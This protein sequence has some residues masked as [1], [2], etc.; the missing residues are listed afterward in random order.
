M[1]KSLLTQ[2]QRPLSVWLELQAYARILL[3]ANVGVPSVFY[4]DLF[5]MYGPKGDQPA[6]VFQ[7]PRYQKILVKMMLVRRFYAYGE[8]GEYFEQPH[9]IGF[10]RHGDAM[11]SNGAGIA[12]LLTSSFLDATKWMCVGLQHAGKTYTDILGGAP[13]GPVVINEHGWG[14]FSVPPRGVSIFVE[15]EAENRATVETFSINNFPQ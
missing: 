12:V 3:Q 8:Q 5:G 14:N 15:T 1:T 2:R 4:G 6:G 7:P 11:H 9:C 10:T 13:D